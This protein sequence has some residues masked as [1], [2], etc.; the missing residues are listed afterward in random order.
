MSGCNI[1]ATN[2]HALYNR[3]TGG[4]QKFYPIVLDF[5]NFLRDMNVI[6]S[7]SD[8]FLVVNKL[9]LRKENVDNFSFDYMCRKLN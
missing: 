2:A 9:K 1:E 3:L 7:E 5:N 6:I 4:Y 8:A